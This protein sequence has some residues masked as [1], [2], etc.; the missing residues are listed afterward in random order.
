MVKDWSYLAA[1]K[2]KDLPSLQAMA[3]HIRQTHDTDMI[4]NINQR[5]EDKT[6]ALDNGI[7][8]VGV[9][10]TEDL[11]VNAGLQQCI[12]II[13]GTSSTRWTLIDT[14]SGTTPPNISDTALTNRFSSGSVTFSSTG[15]T[16]PKGMKLFF[17]AVYGETHGQITS[18][19]EC[20]VFTAVNGTMLNHEVFVNNPLT[21]TLGK[22]VF[23]VSTVVEFCPVA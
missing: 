19:S 23:I 11:V 22:I 6:K 1:F 10:K 15:W 21:R 20:G 14:G 2:R 17:G 5:F 18:I 12:N 3:E 4:E 9:T 13:I 7:E 8:I 16:E